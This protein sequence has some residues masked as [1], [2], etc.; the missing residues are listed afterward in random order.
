M[1][2]LEQNWRI[3]QN[4]MDILIFLLVCKEMSVTAKY[5]FRRLIIM[6]G[7]QTLFESGFPNLI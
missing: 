6:N 4:E 3:F 5:I 2:I 7:N 1:T